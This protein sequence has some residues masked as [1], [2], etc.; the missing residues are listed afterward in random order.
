[1][2]KY[3]NLITLLEST[4]ERAFS[5]WEIALFKSLNKRKGKKTKHLF[6]N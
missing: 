4:N 1:M 6:K 3:R 5:N 2:N